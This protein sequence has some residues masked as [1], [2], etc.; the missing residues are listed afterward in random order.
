MYF[1]TVDETTELELMNVDLVRVLSNA[2]SVV[3]SMADSKAI[4]LQFIP[5][6]PTIVV[7]DEQ[8]VERMFCNLISNA[9]KYSHKDS[10]VG[11]GLLNR[12][13][14][15]ECQIKDQGQGIAAGRHS[16]FCILIPSH[17]SRRHS[18]CP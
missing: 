17:R 14:V 2:M 12:H 10:V 3:Q 1:I 13:D 18:R 4:Q 7:A 11:I 9:I 6:E 5:T 8:L 16:Q 15:I